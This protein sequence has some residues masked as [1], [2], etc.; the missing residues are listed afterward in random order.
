MAKNQVLVTE[1]QGGQGL[2]AL[3]ARAYSPD[4]RVQRGVCDC[5]SLLMNLPRPA[6]LLVSP[7]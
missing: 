6:L 2:D 4:E 3:V 1:I 5:L 7:K